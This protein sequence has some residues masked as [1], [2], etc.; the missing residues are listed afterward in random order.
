MHECTSLDHKLL[1][2]GPIDAAFSRAE[3]II[4]LTGARKTT[5]CVLGPAAQRA[6]WRAA[7]DAARPAWLTGPTK[8]VIILQ[9]YVSGYGT[10]YQ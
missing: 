2:Q 10:Y 9:T 3:L 5:S 6:S 1:L 4:G 8:Y 7:A